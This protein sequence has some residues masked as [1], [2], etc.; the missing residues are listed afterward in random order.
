MLDGKELDEFIHLRNDVFRSA[1]SSSRDGYGSTWVA[2]FWMLTFNQAHARTIFFRQTEH[3][4]LLD[5]DSGRIDFSM[6]PVLAKFPCC[7]CCGP[8]CKKPVNE[9]LSDD[10]RH[11][12]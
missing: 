5:S 10:A 12:A 6:C 8:D 1:V 2:F 3:E 9:L 4:E 7:H 11:K